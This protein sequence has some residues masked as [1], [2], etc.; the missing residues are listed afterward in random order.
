[1]NILFLTV[2]R[3]TDINERGI[4]TDL[5]RK[6]KDEG[7]KIVI[8]SPSERRLNI[9]TNFITTNGVQI[10]NV[11]TLNIQKTNIFEKGISTILLEYQFKHAVKK[12]INNVKF[13]LILYSTP[14][15]TFTKVIQKIKQKDNAKTYLLLKDIF[16]QNAVDLEMIRK[17]GLLHRY[18][19]KKEKKLYAI[20]DYIGCMSPANV[21]YLI[22]NNPQINP[23][24]VE[25]CAN[26]IE[27]KKNY[28]DSILKNLLFS[29]YNIPENSTVFLYGGNL[30]K[31]QG[32]S[33][34]LD[35]LMSNTSNSHVFF[36]IVGSG[37]EYNRIKVWFDKNSPKNALLISNLEKSEYDQ[38]VS[39]CDVGLIFLD[40][41]FTIPN[42]PSR[43]LSYLENK[44]PV[45][46]STDTNSDIG[47]IAE[48]NGYGFRV[49]SG[50]IETFN[51][52]IDYL[53]SNNN[54]IQEMGEKG[55][56]FLMSNYSVENSYDTI[57]N[58]YK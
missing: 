21:T 20:S 34:L 53:T 30:G 29:K 42:Y 39:I 50:D 51:K 31:P 7:H 38:L 26:S 54:V 19:R 12:Y 24:I 35:I 3:I 6:F 48:E 9:Q 4:Y 27:P 8:V 5:I 28:K 16:P 10:L 37:T 55:H 33:F 15:I 32:I 45:I 25:V 47:T 58:H 52:R 23:E 41:R 36:V 57:M 2:S 11:K 44:M 14:P 18:F 49:L 46:A 43:L 13:D 56:K 22:N 1:M 40:N 17:N